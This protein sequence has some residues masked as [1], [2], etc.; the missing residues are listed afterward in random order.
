M[1][2]KGFA[3]GALVLLGTVSGYP[4]SDKVNSL[5]QWDDLSFGLY[6]GYVPIPNSQK[7]LHYVTALSQRSPSTDPV[8]VWFNG[9]PGCSSMLGLMQEHGP[10]MLPDGETQ[11]V[12]N[13]NSWNKEANMIY[14][15]SPA[16]VGF[17]T[18]GNPAECKW[19]DFNTADDN[20]Q[21]LLGI[22]GKFPELQ[23]NDLYIS[24]ESYAGIYVPRL[25]ERIDWYIGNCTTKQC[26]YVPNLKGFIVGNGVTDYNF[27]N[28]AQFIEMSF[29][30]GL[31]ATSTY[32]GL[33][34]NKCLTQQD[35]T[36][37]C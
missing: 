20:L 5:W 26:D 16:G 17:S 15:E 37:V 8:I 10:Y 22:M 21:A 32:E 30:Y 36:P 24:G 27:D 33:N 25:V 3:L 19:N 12:K 18:C 7:S 4:A 14:I 6:S 9:G 28:A 1:T 34:E 11:F 13:P 29:W 2:L 35:L 31:I 23:K